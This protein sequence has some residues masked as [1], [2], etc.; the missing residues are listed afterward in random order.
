MV[1]VRPDAWTWIDARAACARLA[2]MCVARPGSCQRELACAGLR[3]RR[4]RAQRI[5]HRHDRI[6]VPRDAATVAERLVERRSER[7]RRVLRGVV[8]ARLV[9]TG[10][11]EDQV[12]AGM[13]GELLEEVVVQ[14]RTGGDPHTACTVESETGC[15]TC[16]AVARTVRATRRP[17]GATGTDARAGA[18]VPRRQVVVRGVAH[19]SADRLRV[20]ADNQS[21]AEKSVTER[22]PVLDRDVEEVRVRLERIEA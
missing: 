15:E 5:V 9:I 16:S 1:R 11:L 21:L 22:E 2:S 12:E 3:D 20:R 14:A 13:E 8:V 17:P 4:P 19:R 6:S 10:A 7:E 18:R